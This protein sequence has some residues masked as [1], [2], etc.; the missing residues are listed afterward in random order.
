MNL[1]NQSVKFVKYNDI[2]YIDLDQ[3][4]ELSKDVLALNDNLDTKNVL[5]NGK[6]YNLK[7]S[8]EI[9]KTNESFTLNSIKQYISPTNEKKENITLK[10][11]IKFDYAKQQITVSGFDFFESVKPYESEGKLEFYDDSNNR[12]NEFKIDLQKYKIDI[13]NNSGKIY[14]PFVML[15]Q[16]IL[17]ESENQLYFNGD[18]VYIFEFNQVHDTKVNDEK[19]NFFQTPKIHQSHLIK[20]IF[21]LT[22]CCS[23]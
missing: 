23:C 17:G 3:F 10:S 7:R 11:Y 5:Y 1:K 22:I 19:K 13:L 12:F 4:V 14:L 15:N 8:F 18:K 21:S 9:N 20:G 6:V 2:D 16:L